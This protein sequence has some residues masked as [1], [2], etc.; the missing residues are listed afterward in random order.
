MKKTRSKKEIVE[1]P[2]SEE[3]SIT[4]RPTRDAA[5]S[6]GFDTIFND[7]RKAFDDLMAPW[8]PTRTFL[9][10]TTAGLPVRAP[11]VDL[12]DEGDQYIVR[13]ELPG[14]S[15][16]M[17]DVELNKD[18]L[19]LKAEKK[20]EEEERSQDYVHRERSYSVCQRTIN[21]PE[22]VDPSKVNGTMKDGVLELRIPKREPKPEEKMKKVELK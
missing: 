7:F 20:T 6:R 8:N 18:M 11:L 10:R 15:K 3:R 22:E 14:Y 4:S 2:S 9:P 5:L 19:N 1:S 12:I 16:D 13:A 21:F 17:V